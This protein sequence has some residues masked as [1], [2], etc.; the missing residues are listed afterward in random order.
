MTNI[1]YAIFSN[2]YQAQINIP[3]SHSK[4]RMI[5]FTD[6]EWLL[7]EAHDKPMKYIHIYEEQGEQFVYKNTFEIIL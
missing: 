6:M 1:M 5:G 4:F 2:L 3:L 7:K